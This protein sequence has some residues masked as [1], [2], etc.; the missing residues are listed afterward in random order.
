MSGDINAIIAQSD[1]ILIAVPSAYIKEVLT[2]VNVGLLNHKKILSAV[3]G[4]VP[5]DD[6]L[7]NE[8]LLKILKYL[9]KI[10]LH[11]WVRAMQKR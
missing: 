9:L 3:K 2:T 10:I 6:V 4:I 1:V 5:E 11:Y 7:L 8:F